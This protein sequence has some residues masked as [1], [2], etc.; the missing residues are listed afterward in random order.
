[1][2]LRRL[3]IDRLPGI[4]A[5][6]EI[7]A[8]GAQIH[9]VHGPNGIGKSSICRAVEALL[10]SDRGP[11]QQVSLSGEFE[12]AGEVWR[13]EREG[14]RIRWR[15]GGDDSPPPPLPPSHLH[16]CYF[17]LLRDLIEPSATGAQDVAVEIR[18]QMTGGFDLPRVIADLFDGPRANHGRA[19]RRKYNETV[20][21]VRRAEAKQADLQ[22]KADRVE[23]ISSWLQDAEQ[24]ARRLE[25]VNRARGLA[26]RKSEL[27]N[28]MQKLSTLPPGLETITGRELEQVEKRQLEI[29]GFED[30]RRSLERDL[31]AAGLA[32]ENSKLKEP[33]AAVALKT[34]RAR[35]EELSR[36]ELERDGARQEHEG[37][38]A[39]LR[40]AVAAVGGNM[41]GDD[42]MAPFDL[43]KHGELFTFLRAAETVRAKSDA[44]DERLRL[45]G[46]LEFSD[47]TRRRLEDYRA[48][49]GILRAWLRAP[50]PERRASRRR[51]IWFAISFALVAIGAALA[52]MV[53]PRL[54]ILPGIGLAI[55]LPALMLRT[56]QPG[57]G[58]RA[59]AQDGFR[60]LAADGPERW[61]VGSVEAR[62]RE[63][64]G[65]AAELSA[66]EVRARD[67]DVDRLNLQNAR[68]G[69]AEEAARLEPQRRS[70]GDSLG[71]EVG[72]AD[73]ELVDL[74]RALDQLRQSR[75]KEGKAADQCAA[76]E[77]KY[78]QR[79]S[80]AGDFLEGHGESRPG[81]G[82]M[83]LAGLG[84]LETRDAQLRTA[85][86]DESKGQASLT[87]T[88]SGLAVAKGELASL[89][90]TAGLAP[91]DVLGLAEL[92]DKLPLYTQLKQNR[93][94]LDSQAQLDASALATAGE[95]ALIDVEENE[96]EG[97]FDKLTKTAATAAGIRETIATIG[98]EVNFARN[99]HEIQNLLT[100]RGERLSEL[101]ERRNETLFAKAGHLIVE[102]V[103]QE[104]QKIQMPAVLET[105]QRLFAHFTHFGY[106]ITVTGGGGEPRLT[107]IEAATGEARDLSELSDGTRA[108]LLLAARMAFAE[109]VEQDIKLPLF[110]DE[111]L[112]QSDPSRYHE[113]VRGLGRIAQDQDRQ[114]FYFTADPMD[115]ARI[116]RA[117][118]EE[119]CPTAVVIDLAAVRNRAAGVPGP[120]SLYVET[121]DPVPPPDGRSAEQYG[122]L[123]GV[124]YLDP[125]RGHAAQHLFHLLW[126][127]LDF[128]HAL[129]LRRIDTVGR[130]RNVADSGAAM[131]MGGRFKIA[132]EVE[133]RADLL[134]VFCE[135]WKQG[136][137]RP[138]DRDVLADSGAL[139]E[140]YLDVVAAI[141]SELAHDAG[142]L[143]AVLCDRDDS[144]LK[145]FRV[146]ST[147]NLEQ[148]FGDHGYLDEQPV[149]EIAD[150]HALAMASPAAEN[151][152]AGVADRCI[153]RWWELA[154][155][156]LE[157][158]TSEA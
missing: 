119:K 156:G 47:A 18:R 129:L 80:D 144:R 60:N 153:H 117:L 66:N 8:A 98:A 148:Y 99:N 57:A 4:D 136:R 77:A 89:F 130:W 44:A 124:P 97:I 90:A 100:A 147:E 3:K 19:D 104:H 59:A 96:L 133:T 9:V 39:E 16:G 14:S 11:G 122:T 114:I 7:V 82:A 32:R 29:R 93:I 51:L 45:L 101:N 35:I 154:A 13:V 111:A 85:L 26:A 27:Q 73:V 17:L 20:G 1:M 5:P 68:E 138:V 41:D 84:Q 67:R 126:D 155:R 75:G 95:D 81:D 92:I 87:D 78:D 151:L 53:D 112:D 38:G 123:I 88:A 6:F 65:A 128:L 141:A 102:A 23:E 46:K 71:L 52:I 21:D 158:G 86:S 134:N 146:K 50:E 48:A 127:D 69:L 79:L 149:L 121:P 83:A 28:L 42:A 131:D 15:L 116:Q 37:A 109:E 12:L 10:W 137:G 125:S 2:K 103:E 108:Q 140:K 61:E 22:Q 113:I 34:W 24:A 157:R 132:S 91:G 135:L 152:A 30:R 106:E 40:V 54:G 33:L 105:A 142:K 56:N 62:L 139:G 74:A 55:L 118:E 120:S 58:D 107:A 72:R 64:D 76:C 94:E 63:L 36:F 143:I 25:F 110:L 49:G 145:G 70:L 43:A 150:L 115:V 31:A